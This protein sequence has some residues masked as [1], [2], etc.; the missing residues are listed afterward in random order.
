MALTKTKLKTY[1]QVLAKTVRE[2]TAR[3]S[4]SDRPAA[5]GF[6]ASFMSVIRNR[7]ASLSLLPMTYAANRYSPTAGD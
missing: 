2:E 3:G 7:T 1:W 5:D 4:H 6:S